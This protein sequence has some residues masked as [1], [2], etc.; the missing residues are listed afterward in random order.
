MRGLGRG[1]HPPAPAR[2]RGARLG[3]GG[4]PRRRSARACQSD[5]EL[6]PRGHAGREHEDAHRPR[7]DGLAQPVRR[8]G[9]RPWFHLYLNA[10]KNNAS[11][12]MSE[13]GGQLRGDEHAAG[14]LG[15]DRASPSLKTAAATDLLPALRVQRARRRQRQDDRT[16]ARVPCREPVA[17]GET[18]RARR[19][20]STRKLPK[21]FARTGYAGD[22][23]LVGQWFPKLGVYEPAGMRG[24]AAG[25]LELPSV[26]RQ[27]RV[28]RRLRHAIDVDDHRPDP[29]RRRRHRRARRAATNASGTTTYTTTRTT[30]TTSPGP[31]RPLVEVIRRFDA[32]PHGT[33]PRSTATPRRELGRRS[34]SCGSAT[35]TCAF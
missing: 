19:R 21:V 3:P 10:F 8:R 27:L 34:T 2:A 15:L 17:P 24:R 14:R 22:F 30:S 11:T 5:R 7:H 31:R 23:F 20:R 28:L 16:V 32:A 4:G 13:S 9:A 12:F 35:S 25:R 29:L 33:Q 6:R 26:P 18:H 1:R